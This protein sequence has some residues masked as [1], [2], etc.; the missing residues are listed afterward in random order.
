M[1]ILI[2]LLYTGAQ[3]GWMTI[4][5]RARL[6][7]QNKERRSAA[8]GVTT[9]GREPHFPCVL[10]TIPHIWDLFPCKHAKTKYTS[11]GDRGVANTTI[12]FHS[13]GTYNR[14]CSHFC[15]SPRHPH[16]T[17]FSHNLFLAFCHCYHLR[18]YSVTF[19]HPQTA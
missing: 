5:G 8:S 2:S 3:D 13:A 17:S 14:F 9:E 19:T 4:N 11:R 6:F 7:P 10:K 12:V 18:N 15:D 16:L 1:D